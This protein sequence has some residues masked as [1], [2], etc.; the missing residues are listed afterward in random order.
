M[1][2]FIECINKL[3]KLYK[4][5]TRLI[6]PTIAMLKSDKLTIA[7]V[8]KIC[9]ESWKIFGGRRTVQHY[10][11]YKPPWSSWKEL[12]QT[13]P[14]TSWAV[15]NIVPVLID[16]VRVHDPSKDK[17][18]I[19]CYFLFSFVTWYR[20]KVIFGKIRLVYYIVDAHNF[21]EV[22]RCRKFRYTNRNRT[23]VM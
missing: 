21:I 8:W 14:L 12:E 9:W 3:Y 16:I 1:V 18:S 6:W 22:A 4:F 17:C 2:V 10:L 7:Q 19:F 5:R 23:L 11:N 20:I 15:G 13:S